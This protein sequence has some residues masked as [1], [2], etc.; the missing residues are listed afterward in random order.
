MTAGA[1]AN[2]VTRVLNIARWFSKPDRGATENFG[3]KFINF[4]DLVLRTVPILSDAN[5]KV[6]LGLVFHELTDLAY[7]QGI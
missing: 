3:W 6:K 5:R 2:K 1:D 7:I 4:S